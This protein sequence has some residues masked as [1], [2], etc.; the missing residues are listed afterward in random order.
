MATTECAT[1]DWQTHKKSCKRQN[2]ILRVDL[3]P[4]YLINPRVTRTLSCPATATFAD[5]HDALQISFGWKNCHLHEFEVLSHSEFIGY[6]SSFSPGAALLLISP[7]ILEG[8]N[9]EE[10]DKCSSNTVLYQILDGEL[11]RG[12][13]ML[14]R[15]D[16]GDDWEHIMVCGGRA[17]PSVNFELLG[18]E[19]H[20]CAEDVGGPSGWIK[21]LEAYD[22]N[23][24]TKDQRQTIDWFEEEAHNKDSYGLRGAAKYTWDKEKLNIALK[25]LDTS[26]L[27]GDALSILLVSLGKEYWFD[28]M[29]VDVIAKLRSKTTVREVT[30]SISAMKHVRNAIQN[31]LAII[32]TDAV[33]MLPTYLAIN[34]ELI[35][36][37]KSG[38]TVIFGFMIANL[39]EPPTFEKYF[40]SSGWGLNWKFG[41]YTRDT[42]EVN[43]Q[44]HLTKSCKATLE[45]Y[46]M[47]ALSLKNAKPEDRVYAGPGS[48]RNQSPAIF[49]KYGRNETKQ[50]YVGWLGDVN[51]EE[52][53][54]KLLLAMCGF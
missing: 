25:E 34:R 54:T 53:T 23:N 30:D 46:G 10:K 17:D 38:G 2:F 3:C 37:V 27:S 20:G 18:G 19:G 26:S 51:V 43:S 22:S 29:Y 45:S 5:L 36:Y 1:K 24:P 44:A 12:K 31:Y 28:G 52:G 49:A 33:F 41:T 32:V 7:D 14:Y 13:T 40:S 21:L 16:F 50:G 35:E 39:A 8:K 9:Q 42:Y 47:K 48:A 11:T 6:K 4:R 15:Y